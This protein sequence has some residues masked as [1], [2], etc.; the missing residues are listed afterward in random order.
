MR[1]SGGDYGSST[2]SPAESR[3]TQCSKYWLARNTRAVLQLPVCDA[4]VRALCVYIHV[5]CE[6]VD[7]VCMASV[8]SY[9]ATIIPPK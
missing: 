6:K 1:V 7:M 9:A 8:I 4:C 3:P 2:A 5:V